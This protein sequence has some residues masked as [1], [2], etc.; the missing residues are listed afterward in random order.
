[1]SDLARF[2]DAQAPVFA[3]ALAEIR[4]GRKRTHWM[5]FIFPQVAGLGLSA[6]SK[7]FAIRGRH[8]AEA[9]LAHPILGARLYECA[10]ALLDLEATSA[11][12]ILGEVDALK[13]RS[14][15]TL[16]AAVSPPGSP[17]H[18]ILERYFGGGHDERT[19]HLLQASE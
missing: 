8:E 19:L 2:V 10:Q 7:R 14:S 9:Y 3:E 16:F 5:W 1:M 17:F 13:L 4:V 15:A 6:T 12:A 11:E 18:R